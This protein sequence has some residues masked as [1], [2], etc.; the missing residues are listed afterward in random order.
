MGMSISKANRK[1]A[2]Q[3]A[4]DDMHKMIDE[5]LAKQHKLVMA[6]VLH[7]KF[8]FGTQRASEL[9][10]EYENL[11]GCISRKEMTGLCLD[12]IERAVADELDLYIHESGNVFYLGRGK[13]KKQDMEDI[14]KM[15]E[16]GIKGV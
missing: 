3:K 2:M 16:K 15:A 4:I 7:T 6:W 1:I 8:G 5:G 9:L 14:R 10:V 12:D 11:W 13:G